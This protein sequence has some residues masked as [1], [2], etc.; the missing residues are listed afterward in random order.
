MRTLL[1][2]ILPV[3]VIAFF[4]S[5]CETEDLNNGVKA[6]FNYDVTEISTGEVQFNNCSENAKSY[7][8]DFGDGK[9][10]NEKDPKHIF[11][12]NFPFRVTLIAINGRKTDT[13]FQYVPAQITVYKPNI[14]I[15][16]LQSIKLSV[17]IT[18]PLGGNLVESIPE[19]NNGWTVNVDSVGMIDQK[20]NY[21]FYES[22]QPDIFQYKKGWCIAQTD[23]KAFFEKNMGLYNFSNSE[24]NDFI[25][26][27]IPKFVENGYYLIYPQTNDIIDTIIQLKFS[28]QPNH[29]NRLFYGI[30]GI[31]KY[32]KIEEPSIIRFNRDGFFIME[33]GVFIK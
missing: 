23:L 15:Y 2:S 25:E 14:Y 3:F 12:G 29:V 27:W 22:E 11:E 8:W 17:N 24:M 13:T 5:G 18:F 28:I 32:T 1:F 20:Y 7:L 26:Y 31:N 9:T 4:V 6:C 33:W 19:Y 10:S 30:A 16:P 21:L